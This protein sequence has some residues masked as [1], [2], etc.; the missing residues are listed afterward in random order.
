[1]NKMKHIK[2]GQA[3]TSH[4]QDLQL[5]LI[6]EYVKYPMLLI[7]ICCIFVINMCVCVCVCVYVCVYVCVGLL[8]IPKKPMVTNTE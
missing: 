4:P 8:K 1:M 3:I 5:A 6:F 7:C 2:T